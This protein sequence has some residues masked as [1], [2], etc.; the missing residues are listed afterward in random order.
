MNK[1]TAKAI[2]LHVAGHDLKIGHDLWLY[3]EDYGYELGSKEYEKITDEIIRLGN[4]LMV[5]ASYF[6]DVKLPDLLSQE[7]K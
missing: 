5:R 6:R 1:R 3:L 4:D 7:A 2:A